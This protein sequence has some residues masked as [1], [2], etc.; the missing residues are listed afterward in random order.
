[1]KRPTDRERAQLLERRRL[2]KAVK[3]HTKGSLGRAIEVAEAAR[4]QAVECAETLQQLLGITQQ[5]L[6]TALSGWRRF[7]GTSLEVRWPFARHSTLR[8]MRACLPEVPDEPK[9]TRTCPCQS[10][11]EAARRISAGGQQCPH[12]A[13]VH[14]HDLVAWWC[15]C[16]NRP[17]KEGDFPS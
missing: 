15:A 4:K 14:R 12:C 11:E 8:R 2:R 7:P 17:L 10:L 13:H 9:A 5:V 3:Q 1:M 6:R 16:C